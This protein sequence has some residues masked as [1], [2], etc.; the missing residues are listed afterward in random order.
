MIKSLQFH[1]PAAFVVLHLFPKVLN[2]QEIF[3][4]RQNRFYSLEAQASRMGTDAQS[5]FVATEQSG[6]VLLAVNYWHLY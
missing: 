5:D 6:L 1:L 2:F 3:P 4:L